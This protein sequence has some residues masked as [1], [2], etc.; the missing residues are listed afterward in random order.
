MRRRR[1][2]GAGRRD[3]MEKTEV[4]GCGGGCGD[5][6]VTRE[7]GVGSRWGDVCREE[8][9]WYE[10]LDKE[11]EGKKDDRKEATDGPELGGVLYGEEGIG[12]RGVRGRRP[13]AGAGGRQGC[14]EFLAAALIWQ[15]GRGTLGGA[16]YVTGVRCGGGEGEDK[17]SARFPTCRR[18]KLRTGR[19]CG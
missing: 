4:V 14:D 15:R 9:A 8:E 13:S 11:D 10:K 7:D 12:S 1:R 17:V 16:A 5:R 3:F 18:P 2:D 19:E 6:G